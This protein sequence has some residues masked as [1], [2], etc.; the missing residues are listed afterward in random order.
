MELYDMNIQVKGHA[1]GSPSDRK[2]LQESAVLRFWH[3]ISPEH[4]R[5]AFF[6][7]EPLWQIFTF[8]GTYVEGRITGL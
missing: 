1:T 7:P 4:I 8:S 3:L 6:K 5:M 2:T